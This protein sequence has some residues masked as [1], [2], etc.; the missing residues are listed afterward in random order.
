MK[1]IGD[2]VVYRRDL[3]EIVD[4][5]EKYFNNKD[6]Y[7]LV[8]VRDKTLKLSVPVENE[9]LIRDLISVQEINDLISSI[10]QIE[11]IDIQNRNVEIEYQK[12][13]QTGKHEDLIRI[14]KTT[15]L[16]NQDRINNHKKVGEKDNHYF[17]LA[18]MYLYTELAQVL[19]M[20][21]DS[22]KEYIIKKVKESNK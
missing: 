1:V 9:N 12:L 11:P 13:L 18:E 17:N 4:I 14:I 15:Y 19:N 21:Y 3:C 20:D 8:P 16:R 6:Y 2:Y 10:P 5:K 22:T 7:I